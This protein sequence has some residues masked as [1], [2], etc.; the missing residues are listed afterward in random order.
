MPLPDP[1]APFRLKPI[2]A[3]RVSEISEATAAAPVAPEERVNFHIGNPLQDERLA[4]LF[5]RIA[6]GVDFRR[7]D[8]ADVNSLLEHLALHPEERPALEFIRQL[9]QK[10]SP[11]APRGGY[12]R[13]NPHPLVETFARWLENQ[14]D[15]L[16]YNLNDPAGKREIILS[17][18]GILET[19]RVLLTALSNYLQVT[20]AQIFTH[21]L[22][23]PPA[24]REI[25]RLQFETLPEDET[26]AYAALES[27]LSAAPNRPTFVLLGA[28]L[29][30]D[31]RRKLRLLSIH[32]PLFFIEANNTLNQRSLAREAKLVQRVIRLLTPA[33]FHP[34]L[35]SLSTV[36]VVG[37]ADLLAVI[38]TVHFALKG[39]PSASEIEWLHFLLE[40]GL[41]KRE[42]SAS[43]TLLEP[44]WPDTPQND[45]SAAG[46][47][48]SLALRV[49]K[50]LNGLAQAKAQTVTRVTESI[51]KKGQ[52]LSHILH[53]RS[54]AFQI[55]E[56]A[57]TDSLTLLHELTAN[58]H[59]PA[60]RKR[61]QHSFLAVFT[62]HQPQYQ[63]EAC[64]V[65][66]GSSRTA[67]GLL[68]F[69]CGITDVVFPDLSWS[70]EQCFPNAHAVPLTE[71]LALDVDAMIAKLTD[72]C[73]AD[74]RWPERGAIALNNPHNATGRIFAEDDIRRLMTWCLQRGI[75]VVDDLAY[76][77]VAPV[78]DLPLIKT[79]RQVADDLV[80]DG[81][82]DERQ[83]ER[84]IS[85]HS[86]SKTDCLA[87]ARLSVVEIRPPELRERFRAIND[88]IQPNLA[89][90]F[91]VYL[92]YRGP[93]EAARA[94]WRLRNTIF[95]E[96]TQAL[97]SAAANL[98]T[99][100]NP[101]GL[102]I[103]PPT[104]SMYPLLQVKRLPNG[105]SLDWL[106]SALA[107]RGIG[108][109]P[110]A[111]FARTEAGFD[112]GRSTFR[113][114][115]GGVDGAGTIQHK[116]RRLLIDLNRLIEEEDAR[117]NRK[118][119]KFTLTPNPSPAGRAGTAAPTLPFSPFPAG[120]EP[121]IKAWDSLAAQISRHFENR[122]AW[123]PLNSLPDIDP[124][125]LRKEFLKTYLPERL[126]LFR[127]RLRERAL[128]SD[129]LM[130]KAAADGNWLAARL[131]REF[132]KDALARR[133]NAFRLRTYDRTVHPT[134]KYSLT[135]EMVIESIQRAIINK[136]PPAP[137]LAEK[138]A[139]ELLREF[140]GL[141]ISIN[142][143][144]EAD[145]ILVDFDALTASEAYI[146][147][148]SETQIPTFLSFWSDW[149]GS[150]RPSG[151][152]HRLAAAAVME[153]VRRLAGILNLLRRANPHLPIAPDLLAE[154]ER[155][156]ERSTRFTQL[157]NQITQLTHQ[158][159]QRYRGFL[160]Y[161]L[162]TSPLERLATR[163]HL[164]R[165]PAEVLWQHNDRYEKK[166][167]E[168]R[169]QRRAMLETWFALNKKL[170]KQLHALIPEILAHRESEPLLRAAAGYHDILQRFV[171]TPRIHQGMITSREQ[172][173][174]ETT[175]FNMQEIN[176]IAGK[177]GN[178][179]LTL[180]L[181]ISMS[182]RPEAL[183]ALDRKMSAQFERFRREYPE[184]ELPNIWLIPLFEDIQAVT[185][186]PDYLDRIWD[187]ATQSRHT[188]Q[189]PQSRLSEVLA[190]IFIAGSDLSQQISQANG[191]FQYVQA[192]YR[193]QTWLAEHG[194]T[195]SIRLKLGSGEPMQRQ[196]GYYSDVAGQPAF[197]DLD[198]PAQRKRL[199]KNLPPAAQRS[200]AYAVTPL[201]GVFVG[202][203][204]RTLQSNIAEHMR[205]LP[206]R[207]LA[208]LLYH[209]RQSQH[210]HRQNLLR[211][212]ETLTES[213]LGVK[214]RGAQEMER[215]TVGLNEPL[216]EGFLN[217]L[218]EH[219]RHI[220]YGRPEDVFGLHIISYFIGRSLPQLRDRP[221]SR[222]RT[223]SG[224]DRG[225]QIVASVAEM[226]P[227]SK[228]GSMLRAISHNQ[229]QTAILGINQLTTGLFR[230]LEYYAQKAF[231]ES[232]R[233]G[234]MAERILPRLPVYDI[235]NTLRLYQD[236][237]GEI[238]R[239]IENA[240]PAGHASFVALRE[241]HDAMLRFLP[242]FQQELLR[243]H[244]LNVGDFFQNGVFLP[245]LL[246]ALRPDLAVLLQADLFN[247]DFE[248][249]VAKTSAKFSPAWQAET[250]RL[251]RLPDQ[252]R[253]WRSTIWNLMGDSIEQRV[254][255]FTELAAALHAFSATR[256]SPSLR[257]TPSG[258]R[259]PSALAGFL[260][261]SRVDDEMRQFLV[262]AMEQLSHITESSLE[263]PVSIIRAIKDVER[264]AQ[265]EEAA[266]PPEKQAVLRLCVLQIARLTGE[267][268]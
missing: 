5:L 121:G 238:T 253:Y 13:K 216:Y 204:L 65:T 93:L 6:L 27:A 54:N 157:L 259:L 163:L 20:P 208:N 161:S 21:C 10:S 11:Y 49:G 79:A 260:R 245:D 24:W 75:Y 91:I 82:I 72:L 199:S 89:A 219:F 31:S 116:A 186:I 171:I 192:K 213:R 33:I 197:L 230:A 122:E 246:P 243:R 136:Q 26:A 70:Y 32:H 202:G 263:V 193:I 125:H 18:G 217:E 236:W 96:R 109:L 61:L 90:I 104:G 155:L 212:A 68:G 95:K 115:L 99:E 214:G 45:L 235:L 237:R 218:T 144:R 209:L 92:F 86:M 105:L 182:T 139:H 201:Q 183:V 158:L 135:A 63:P 77:N 55:D 177:Y 16:C 226:I 66:S 87:G 103:L 14:P 257:P 187:Y 172:F 108:L 170:R 50:R 110:L 200:T 167:L 180:A 232:E 156:P 76:Q 203:D 179:G 164:R 241:D 148:F 60:W 113:L 12:N 58:L 133:Q 248:R 194:L 111:S 88:L 37:N 62:L 15:P 69:H 57:H 114:T 1:L 78:D 143:E 244:G 52:H 29:T 196:G 134:Q 80:R 221:T 254:Q 162:N 166:M 101:F 147:L 4:S 106:A 210:I 207:D 142:S 223:A 239:R 229:A 97:L 112:T 224:A 73:R 195:E 17:S 151:Q 150:N 42:T 176:A 8:L 267:N 30:E 185:G 118:E 198:Q 124:A 46:A 40:N 83:A 123:K 22:P 35:D 240:F 48:T 25:P 81:L 261:S 41:A 146:E 205:F 265:I 67:L 130:R 242:L 120:E 159:E 165:D 184:S 264:I 39:T 220:L 138:A 117:Y 34:R 152:G 262:G 231:P 227:L 255:S 173:A 189:T 94:Y 249:M 268:G 233:E 74:P 9:I 128:I 51:E 178:P 98:P 129:E 154:L 131:E 149:D 168:L 181:Q 153:N 250:R 102:T 191:A 252:V 7:Q 169:A 137:G 36:F 2:R 47:L 140:L 145:E 85:V 211:A 188:D 3:A 225:Q 258:G 266:L 64:L 100:R 38:E 174:I 256:P 132:M 228:Q 251:L 23:L 56:F 59:N 190:E 175:A 84:V 247:T 215:L 44:D 126:D 119:L 206:V 53:N 160:P 107:R 28:P 222:R 43:T 127:Q 234:L 19:L 71:D 141:N